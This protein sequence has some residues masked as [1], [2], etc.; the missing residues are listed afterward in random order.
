M[1]KNLFFSSK[2]NDWS[3]PQDFYD[4]LDEEFHFDL[5]PCASDDNH[6]CDK[7]FTE[8]EDGLLQNWGGCTVFCNP[9]YGREVK[10]WVKKCAEEAKKPNTTV[11]LLI[12]ARTETSYFHDYIYNKPNV[13]VRFIR[14]RLH[15]GEN[16]NPAPFG[17]MVVVFT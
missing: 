6:K 5:D 7:Y 13:E 10:K 8:A 14:G 11:V 4:T 16:K 3:T 2:S 17:S 15:F 12:F 1:D 9:P